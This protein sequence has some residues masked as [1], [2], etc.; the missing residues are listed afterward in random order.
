MR[1]L[2]I[3]VAAFALAGC[4]SSKQAQ[5]PSGGGVSTAELAKHE[6]DFR[7]SDYDPLPDSISATRM[8][9]M[10]GETSQPAD[11]SQEAP[12]ELVQGFRVQLFSSREIDEAKEKKAEAETQFPGEWFYLEYDPPIYKIR[13]GNFT[14]RFDAEQL[15]GLLAEKGY[16]DA[17]VVP[18]K[19]YKHPGQPAPPPH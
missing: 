17:W 6:A 4:S 10:P 7:P 18:E 12:L 5:G 13:A 1:Q 16:P 3:V 8:E 9:M 15:R 11:T 19:V 2:I 14:N